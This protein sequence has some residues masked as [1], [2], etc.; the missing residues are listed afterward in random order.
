MIRLKEK[1]NLKS[2]T[3]KYL[4][5]EYIPEYNDKI[6]NYVNE[7]FDFF[8]LGSDQIWHPYVNDTPNL[9]FAN[10]T[11]SNKKIFFAPSSGMAEYS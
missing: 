11:T 7:K 5:V 4:N 9:Y 8:V 2:S 1:E 10:F 6:I 3:L